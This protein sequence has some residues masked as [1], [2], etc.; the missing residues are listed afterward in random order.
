MLDTILR[1]FPVTVVIH[2]AHVRVYWMTL[3]EIKWSSHTC[4]K[5]VNIGESSQVSETI[6]R[7]IPMEQAAHRRCGLQTLIT[8]L[9]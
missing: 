8:R 6:Q 3:R 7:R 2:P 4:E 1:Y 5:G 9:P